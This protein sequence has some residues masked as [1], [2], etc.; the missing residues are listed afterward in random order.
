MDGRCVKPTAG[1]RWYFLVPIPW[2]WMECMARNM[3]P[4]SNTAQT[5][6]RA[7]LCLLHTTSPQNPE[8]EP[9]Y[10]SNLMLNPYLSASLSQQ[11]DWRTLNWTL[12]WSSWGSALCPAS[13]LSGLI[14]AL[15][16]ILQ[17]AGHSTLLSLVWQRCYSGELGGAKDS[18][19]NSA[20]AVLRDVH[21]GPSAPPFR[22]PGSPPVFL[23][24]STSACFDAGKQVGGR[25]GGVQ[26]LGCQ[27]LFDACYSPHVGIGPQESN[28]TSRW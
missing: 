13:G 12:F 27:W 21:N 25:G 16:D 19:A 17:T 9:L 2:N 7:P 4:S 1:R 6:P 5:P 22:R 26:E 10:P 15:C 3:L 14:L 28:P 23:P 11:A 20:A 18:I 8:R 24:Q